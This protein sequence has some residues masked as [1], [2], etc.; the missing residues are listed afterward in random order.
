[1]EKAIVKRSFNRYNMVT[2]YCESRRMEVGESTLHQTVERLNTVFDDL[3]EN[4]GVF[5]GE[6]R[7]ENLNGQ[8]LQRWWNK[9][10][11]GKKHST[12]NNYV[13]FLNP[14]LRWAFNIGYLLVDVSHVLHTVRIPTLDTIPEWER[15]AEKYLTHR[16]ATVLLDNMVVGDYAER[17]R[18][19]VALFLF[20]GMRVSELCSL[21]IGSV[22][23]YEKGLIYCKRKGGRWSY[24]D[25]GLPFYDYLEEYLKT[26]TD[27]MTDSSPLFLS[28]RGGHLARQSVYEAIAPVQRALGLATGPHA[29]RHTYISEMEKIGGPAIARDLANHKSFRI[30]NRYDHSTAKQRREALANLNWNVCLTDGE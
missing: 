22:S 23:R 7:I 9:F 12:V 25:V 20:S 21:T 3:T 30:T 14:F 4:Y 15:P 2:F 18:A 11:V 27:V 26:R 24:V 19:I 16:D 29:L 1:M 6:D 13:S 10:T 28:K 5:V 8:I 17:N